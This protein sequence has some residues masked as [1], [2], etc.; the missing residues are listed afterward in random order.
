MSLSILQEVQCTGIDR[1]VYNASEVGEENAGCVSYI[2][3]FEHPTDP[4]FI[5]MVIEISEPG[6]D[7][8]DFPMWDGRTFAEHVNA[9]KSET[10]VNMEE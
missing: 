2:L 10:E 7:R 1:K 9:L 5:G 4:D 3:S 6:I 8:Y